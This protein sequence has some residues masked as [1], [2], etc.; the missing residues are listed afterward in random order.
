MSTSRVDEPDGAPRSVRD[1]LAAL[2]TRTD[3]WPRVPWHRTLD[4]ATARRSAVLVL[5]GVLDS[6][7]A[8]AR[9]AAVPRDV[10]VLLTRR[11]DTVGHH[12]GQVSFPGG[13]ID[14]GDD[15][16]VGA[17]LREAREE[18]GLDP[19]GVEVLGS[20]PALPVAVSNNLVTPV[21]AWWARP[22]AVAAADPAET[23]HVFRVPVADL[24]DPALRRTSTLT[25]GGTTY[26]GPA[27][28][29]DGHVVWGFTAHVLDGL[30][31]ALGWT[32]PWDAARTVAIAT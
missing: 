10:D 29:V 3:T 22:S 18:T 17:A 4:P 21:L 23:V 16:P 32:Q 20:L 24:L 19:S 27:F 7:P 28:L 30:F 8:H 2:C 14:P 1:E 11:S 5:F 6:V 9:A 31:D 15:G 12:P 26:R 25:R 13:G